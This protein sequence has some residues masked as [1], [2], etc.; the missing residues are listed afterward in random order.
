MQYLGPVYAE[1]PNPD[2]Y[3]ISLRRRDVSIDRLEDLWP[4]PLRDDYGAHGTPAQWL[5]T[6]LLC[7]TVNSP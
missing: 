1:C 5:V 7:V 4:T 2:A 3:L 6:I